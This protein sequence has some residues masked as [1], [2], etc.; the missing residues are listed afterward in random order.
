MQGALVHLS[1]GHDRPDAIVRRVVGD[2][3]PEVQRAR[4]DDIPCP[5][6][7]YCRRSRKNTTQM[8]AMSWRLTAEDCAVLRVAVGPAH[9]AELH[10][11]RVRPGAGPGERRLLEEGQEAVDVVAHS[12]EA[13]DHVATR[14]KEVLR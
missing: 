12:L 1:V 3:V 8:P 14:T 11:I 9:P 7:S 13:V 5:Q 2:V 6:R 10:A 4:G